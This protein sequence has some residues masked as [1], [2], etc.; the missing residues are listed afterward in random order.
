K[1][2]G[3]ICCQEM[4]NSATPLNDCMYSADDVPMNKPYLEGSVFFEFS[5]FGYGTPKRSDYHH[6]MR[7]TS[8][9]ANKDFISALP[10]KLIAHPHGPIGFFGHVDTAWLHG[11]ADPKDPYILERWHSRI[12]PFRKAVDEILK[13]QTLGLVLDTM[14]ENYGIGNAMIAS[15]YDRFRSGHEIMTPEKSERLVEFWITR[16]D[17][18]NYMLFG[19]PGTYVRIPK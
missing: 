14:N 17:A 7:D 11:F 3:A 5:C 6:W 13:T 4:Q 19:D 16:S 18:Q 15:A 2:N 10:K 12:A 9:N 8:L 1:Y